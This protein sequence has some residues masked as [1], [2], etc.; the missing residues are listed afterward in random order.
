MRDL[1]NELRQAVKIKANAV[2]RLRVVKLDQ[3]AI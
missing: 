2:S 3:A 1:R